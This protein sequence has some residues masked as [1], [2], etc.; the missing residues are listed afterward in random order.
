M[1]SGRKSGL[2][3]AER[4]GEAF[5]GSVKELAQKT[6]HGESTIRSKARSSRGT[7]TADGWRYTVINKGTEYIAEKEGEDPIEGSLQEIADL[8]GKE[9]ET[10]RLCARTGKA[11]KDGWSVK[12]ILRKGRQT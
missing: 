4:D 2:Y 10:M 1:K 11:T 5:E 9:Y 8:T 6:G 3:R 12:Q 7:R